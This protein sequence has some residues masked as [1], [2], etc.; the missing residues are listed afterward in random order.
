MLFIKTLTNFTALLCIVEELLYHQ[1]II[2][3]LCNNKTV[4]IVDELF[5]R[6]LQN[7]NQK[8]II[9]NTDYQNIQSLTT[10]WENL[11]DFLI[12]TFLDNDF[13]FT[14]DMLL[15]NNV[16][17]VHLIIM[18]RADIH[19]PISSRSMDTLNA[20]MDNYNPILIQWNEEQ[21]IKA[22]SM[23]TRNELQP[24]AIESIANLCD[25]S[26][27]FM[28]STLRATGYIHAPRMMFVKRYDNEIIGIGGQ[29][30]YFLTLLAEYFNATVSIQRQILE[31][32]NVKK[33][34]RV[35]GATWVPIFAVSNS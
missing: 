21:A 22:Y 31:T 5:L 25:R 16:Y 4:D 19:Q 3:L 2:F 33:R 6:S 10:A 24:I 7:G 29:D 11:N 30:G 32:D 17:V 15:S 23:C 35:Y 28:G 34:H 9:Y 8:Y 20:Q 18:H 26:A 1:H 12:V 27:N 13:D 14:N